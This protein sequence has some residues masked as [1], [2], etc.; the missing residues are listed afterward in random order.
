MSEL[1]NQFVTFEL[2][3]QT[4]GVNVAEVAEVIRM[5]GMSRAPET[6]PFVVGLVNIR[7]HVVPAVDMRARLHLDSA[8]YTLATPILI[9]RTDGT[10]VGLVVDRVLEVMT[11]PDNVIEQPN[12]MFSRSQC[13]VGVAKVEAKM[14][15]LIDLHG[16]FTADEA[17]LLEEMT[18]IQS[19]GKQALA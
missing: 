16:I 13:L 2:G 11:L 8:S 15:F 14:I 17:Q 12:N 9:T 6:L 10:T 7:G 3:G 5:V 1:E 19:H 4:Y 18:A